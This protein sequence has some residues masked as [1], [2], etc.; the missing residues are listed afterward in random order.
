MRVDYRARSRSIIWSSFR[1]SSKQE[2]IS[3]GILK[4][5][6]RPSVRVYEGAYIE[7]IFMSRRW[8][9]CIGKGV[10]ITLIDC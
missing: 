5:T 9:H 3:G 8:V 7:Y 6:I 1:F 4:S 2:G 10:K